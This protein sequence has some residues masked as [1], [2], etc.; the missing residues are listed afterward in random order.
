MKLF[1]VAFILILFSCSVLSAPEEASTALLRGAN[2]EDYYD[3]L[4]EVSHGA[5]NQNLRRTAEAVF[6]SNEEAS[7][8]LEEGYEDDFGEDHHEGDHHRRL[9]VKADCVRFYEHPDFKGKY[10]E[11][12]RDHTKRT[13]ERREDVAR[14]N[15][16]WNDNISS[17]KVGRKVKL[18]V[19]EH[20]SFGG[21]VK[22]FGPGREVKNLRYE[23]R[24]RKRSWD[25]CISGFKVVNAEPPFGDDCVRFYEHGGYNGN[26]YTVC[27]RGKKLDFASH[28][29][30]WNDRISSMKVGRN[31][32]V[33]IFDG[34]NYH[35]SLAE[36]DNDVG[37]MSAKDRGR[38]QNWNDVISSIEVVG[39]YD[40][41]NCAIDVRDQS[42]EYEEERYRCK[43]EKKGKPCRLPNKDTSKVVVLPDE[44]NYGGPILRSRFCTCKVRIEDHFSGSATKEYKIEPYSAVRPSWGESFYR[45][46]T[47]ECWS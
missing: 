33:R 36:F 26:S 20:G 39:P 8:L 35:G 25:D 14:H 18:Y 30:D 2:E 28:V 5:D 41:P 17:L 47:A 40:T 46:F 15:R 31:V 32:V 44:F 43:I 42:G 3:D 34:G 11:V 10:Y 27:G 7:T 4:Q 29:H 6:A 24:G 45:K 23:K 13:S 19:F 16:R 9:S 22:E 1:S 21:D 12:C 37:N 38:G